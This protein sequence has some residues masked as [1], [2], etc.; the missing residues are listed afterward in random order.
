VSD[1]P[2]SEAFRA[3]YTAHHASL[4][5]Y[6]ARRVERGEVEDLVAERG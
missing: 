3:I 6:F 5:A 4:C 1:R 2:T